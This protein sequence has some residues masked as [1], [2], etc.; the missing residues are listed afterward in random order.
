[1][2]SLGLGSRVVTPLD[3]ASAYS[4]I[5]AGGVYSKPMAIRRVVL[6]D[7]TVSKAGWGVPEPD[8]RWTVGGRS[9]IFLYV[10]GP[11]SVLDLELHGFTFLGSAIRPPRVRL[12]GTQGR[13][14]GVTYPDDRPRVE[15]ALRQ[16][17]AAG[18]YPER[19]WG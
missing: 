15:A 4:T 10:A 11:R 6:A 14:L 7:G 17:V 1:M 2:P 9:S 19:L 18:E 5:A 13:W 12:L 16:L 3:L 8:G